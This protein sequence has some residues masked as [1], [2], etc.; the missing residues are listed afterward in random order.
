MGAIDACGVCNGPGDIYECGCEPVPAGDCDC[1]G[2]Q[3][4]EWACVAVKGLSSSAVVPT[5]LQATAIA[6]ATNSTPWGVAA[7]APQMKT[8]TG[9]DDADDCVGTLDDCGVCNGPG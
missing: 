7:N 2:N 1:N 3:L 9:C 8:G 6:T 4:D 5:S